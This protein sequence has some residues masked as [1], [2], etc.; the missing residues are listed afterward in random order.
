MYVYNVHV[1]VHACAFTCS[2]RTNQNHLQFI[3]VMSCDYCWP[4]IGQIRSIV[5]KCTLDEGSFPMYTC[6]YVQHL[7]AT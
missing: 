3:T 1:R 7:Y 4:L 5:K 6:N 2:L